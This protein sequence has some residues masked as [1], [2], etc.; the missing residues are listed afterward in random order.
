MK[1][2]LEPTTVQRLKASPGRPPKT[3]DETLE[4]KKLRLQKAAREFE[5]FFILH[6]LRAMRSTIPKS[7]L[8]GG[9]LGQDVYTAMFDEELSREVAG[10]SPDSLSELLY[11]S[12][13]KHL[14]ASAGSVGE[15][16]AEVETQLSRRSPVGNLRDKA[17]G[18]VPSGEMDKA[19]Q[20]SETKSPPDV[21]APTV[22][23]RPKI[24][25]DPILKEY[26]A[27]IAKAARQFNVDPKLIY[28][29]IHAESSG[30]AD[31]IS[32]KG[33][34]GLMQLIDSTA[35]DMGV[36]DT[37]DPHQN[38]IGGTKYLRRLLDRYDGN[39][40]LALAAYNAGPGAVSKYNGV[41]PYRET[42]NY[43]EKVLGRLHSV[44]KP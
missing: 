30:R 6:M 38:I 21:Y 13:E 4:T 35:T 2:N 29:V 18:Q 1:I 22:T 3:G 25:G 44:K 10:S 28:S 19:P 24:S 9:G 11:A 27:T 15:K 16:T 14:E 5:S 32:P 26:G 41:P 34:K 39:V 33:A 31:A 43:I 17:P 23:P 42:R 36:A 20:A 12:L 8:L 40:K 7:D 37:L